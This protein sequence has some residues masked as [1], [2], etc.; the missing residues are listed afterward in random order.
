MRVYLDMDG[1]LC[2]FAGPILKKMNGYS[3]HP[4]TW[5]DMDPVIF[6]VMNRTIANNKRN[7]FVLSDIMPEAR[8]TASLNYMYRLIDGDVDFWVNLPWLQDGK[9]LWDYLK[10]YEDLYILTTPH[11]QASIYGKTYWIKDNLNFDMSKV[12][13]EKQ[14]ENY[15]NPNS[16]LI[17]DLFKN[18]S[19][20]KFK[21]GEGIIH[22]N[23]NSTIKQLKAIL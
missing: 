13:F 10:I 11:D 2:D 17:D 18:I 9:K 5:K 1:V 15:A 22:K 20:F 23:F 16:V 4:E 8:Q 6:K 12:I 7:Y 19:K 3:E 14:K 21:G